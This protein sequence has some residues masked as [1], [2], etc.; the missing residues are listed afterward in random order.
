MRNFL[1]VLLLGAMACLLVM[2]SATASAEASPS[3][4]SD[5]SSSIQQKVWNREHDYWRYVQDNNLAAYLGLWHKD[6]LGWPSVSNTPV[7][8]D[9]ITDWIASQTA[10]GLAFKSSAFKPAK[11]QVTGDVTVACYWITYTWLDKD[12]K[13]DSHT[14][15]ITHAWLKNGQDWQIIGGMSMPEPAPQRN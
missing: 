8:K 3:Q 15:R 10:K 2:A 9:H 7:G 1:S 5:Q 6:F 12:G 4:V 11:I 13:G 14:V